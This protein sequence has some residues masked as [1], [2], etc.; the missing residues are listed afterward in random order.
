MQGTVPVR[1]RKAKQGGRIFIF[2]VTEWLGRVKGSPYRVLAIP[3]DFSLYQF[4]E[5]ITASFDFYLDHPFGYYNHLTRYW[6]ATESYELF[7]DDPDIRIECNPFTKSVKKTRVNEVFTSTGRMMLFLFDYGDNWHFR[8]EFLAVE[9]ENPGKSYPEC[10][11]SV[12]K[13]RLQYEDDED[14]N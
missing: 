2:K 3:E 5:I 8:I 12:G 14:D 10:I 4:A 6:E 7:F 9:P 11:Q 13:A 1:A